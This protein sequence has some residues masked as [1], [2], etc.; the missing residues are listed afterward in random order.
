MRLAAL[1]ATCN[2]VVAISEQKT[3]LES[4]S[5]LVPVMFGVLSTALN[6]TD[7][8]VFQLVFFF[9]TLEPRVERSKGLE[10]YIR[11]LLGTASQF[12]PRLSREPRPRNPES[13]TSNSKF[14]TSTLDPPPCMRTAKYWR[15]HT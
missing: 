13:C 9:I 14:P 12:C 8:V 10:P 4:T 11:A 5:G 7:E 3:T 2:F 1:S 6:E 15:P